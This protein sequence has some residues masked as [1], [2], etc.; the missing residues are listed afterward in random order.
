M[1]VV[2]HH[3]KPFQYPS[4]LLTGFK[5]ALLKGE[6]SALVYKQVLAIIAP[7][8]DVVNRTRASIRRLRDIMMNVL[9]LEAV[10]YKN[11]GMTPFR[12]VLENGGDPKSLKDPDSE[13]L[14]VARLFHDQ[15][16]PPEDYAFLIDFFSRL[17]TD[18]D[19]RDAEGMT[20]LMWVATSRNKAAL[21]VILDRGAKLDV[22]SKDG[23][24]ALMWAACSRAIG[25]MKIL[26]AAGA[27]ESL[28]DPTGRTATEW[29]AW[30]NASHKATTPPRRAH[31]SEPSNRPSNLS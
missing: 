13:L 11:Y 15:I 7:V 9:N 29:F 21:K 12:N 18:I 5:K 26:V 1:K 4:A 27:N 31:S 24:T 17:V 2:R 6:V 30:T 14:R 10:N 20:A 8:D 3:A 22:R 19:H 28:R 16:T 23:R 25:P